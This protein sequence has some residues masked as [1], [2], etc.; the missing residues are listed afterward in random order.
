[1][2]NS[3]IQIQNQFPFYLLAFVRIA[4][5]FIL[6]PVF[7][8]KNVPAKLKVGFSVIITIL[9]IPMI[10]D[11]QKISESIG[12]EQIRILVYVFRIFTEMAIG[13]LMGF[14][15]VLFLNIALIAG[16]VIDVSMGLG[17]GSVFD[18]Q[19]N[20]Q[21]AI[22][23]SLL[24]TIMFIYFIIANGHLHLI[25]ALV[26]TFETIPVGQAKLGPEVAQVVIDQFYL[27][28]SLA[29]TLMLPIVAITLIIEA[30]MGV[31]TRAIPQ[32]NAYMVGIP[33]KILAGFAILLF[34]QPLYIGFCD[35]VF[36]KMMMATDKLLITLH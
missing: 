14:I 7:G 30:I 5:L 35:N 10:Q 21:T 18:P 23:G 26:H 32:L 13:L 29:I 22:S 1:M 34:L 36:E 15:T 9:V 4:S 6:S 12:F 31:L 28:F 25:Q 20:T 11:T 16:Q 2:I 8:R 27:S 33:V 24:N 3:L 17:I 19:M